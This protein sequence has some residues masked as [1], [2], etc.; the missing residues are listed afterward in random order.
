MPDEA[1]S[2]DW[3][4]TFSDEEYRLL[5]LGFI[6]IVPNDDWFAFFEDG[7]FFIHWKSSGQCVCMFQINVVAGEYQLTNAL[8]NSSMIAGSI[9]HMNRILDELLHWIELTE[10]PAKRTDWRNILP[11]PEKKTRLTLDVVIETQR[12]E[13]LRWGYIP[14]A[15]EDHWFYFMEDNWLYLHRSWTGF[16]VFQIKFEPVDTGYMVVETWANRDPNQYK[17]DDEYDK[18]WILDFFFYT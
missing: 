16:C 7:T 10:R 15:M 2:L 11:M 9:S 1:E 6:P 17:G 13:K 4:R 14:R 12:Y 5:K 18:K 8:V 3:N